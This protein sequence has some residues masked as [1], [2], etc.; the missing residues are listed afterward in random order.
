MLAATDGKPSLY[1]PMRGILRHTAAA[2]CI[3]AVLGASAACTEDPRNSPATL[4]PLRSTKPA[5][6][7]ATATATSTI[8]TSDREQIRAIYS[9]FELKSLA[10]S[11]LSK[12]PR[13][14]YLGRWLIEPGLSQWVNGMEQLRKAGQ[15]DTGA[16]KPHIFAI[17][18]RGDKAELDDC[19][20][21]SSIRTVDGSGRVISKG[22][23]HKWNVTGLKRTAHGWRIYQQSYKDE[24]CVG[25]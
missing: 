18:I 6:P 21:E 16:G 24:S 1:G 13:R 2:T 23:R 10:A 5:S 9:E 14:R 4:S 19:T 3:A 8:G 15:Y 22:Q 17:I 25:K 11:R 12:S 7:S 20:D